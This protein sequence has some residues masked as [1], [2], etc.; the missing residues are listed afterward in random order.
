MSTKLFHG[1]QIA[2]P[3][4][5]TF[6]SLH[7]CLM[8]LRADLIPQAERLLNRQLIRSA[9]QEYDLHHIGLKPHKAD[10]SSLTVAFMDQLDLLDQCRRD[11]RRLPSLDM[12]FSLTLY[13]LKD[14][15]VL[16]LH[17]SEQQCF[18]DQWMAVTGV[19]EYAYWNNTDRP[20][21]VSEAEWEQRRIS[22]DQ[23]FAQW[24]TPSLCGYTATI[25]SDSVG[26][27]FSTLKDDVPTFAQPFGERCSLIGLLLAMHEL[28]I[29][30]PEER[31][32]FLKGYAANRLQLTL[33]TQ[34]T[35]YAQAQLL[36][37]LNYDDLSRLP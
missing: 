8:Q 16:G 12:E 23:V 6:S 21:H 28:G 26:P 7:D 5:T 22:W 24:D 27:N 19:S 10:T 13:P 36:E 20:E 3:G 4:G 11:R 9:V 18:I 31:A 29:R 34:Q 30:S 1:F 37:D 15:R 25:V 2:L 14:G 32:V 33:V 35:E 17:F